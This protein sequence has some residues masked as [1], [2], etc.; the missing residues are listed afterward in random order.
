MIQ[1]P[2]V[3]AMDDRVRPPSPIFRRP[4]PMLIPGGPF[5]QGMAV[6]QSR[7]PDLA[8]PGNQVPAQMLRQD[9]GVRTHSRIG[10]GFSVTRKRSRRG[11]SQASIGSTNVPVEN[12]Q[13]RTAPGPE[14]SMSAHIGNATPAR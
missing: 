5:Q 11:S 7:Q 13:Y 8:L 6:R 9:P 14:P 2:A 1:N 10:A 4:Q 12:S 3:N